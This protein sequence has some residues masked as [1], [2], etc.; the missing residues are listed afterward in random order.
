VREEPWF[1]SAL[2]AQGLLSA[3]GR[4]LDG[5]LDLNPPAGRRALEISKLFP[6]LAEAELRILGVKRVS[7]GV[8][9]QYRRLVREQH[10]S[11]LWDL[12]SRSHPPR[13]LTASVLRWLSGKAVMVTW[14]AVFVPFWLGHSPGTTSRLSGLLRDVLLVLQLFDDLVDF[15]VDALIRQPNAVL[16]AAGNPA[17]EDPLRFWLA[18]RQAVGPVSTLAR[19][20]LRRLARLAPRRSSFD[21][22]CRL[23]AVS[24]DEAERLARSSAGSQTLGAVLD[25]LDR[26]LGLNR[27]GA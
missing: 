3:Y 17:P 12:R 8:S 21:K 9:A 11:L 22:V 25:T 15:P 26:R 2:E 16:I 4:V 5:V 6:L 18:T 13:S 20:L 14:P 7:P 23:L 1:A 27:A 10:R 19:R 24:I